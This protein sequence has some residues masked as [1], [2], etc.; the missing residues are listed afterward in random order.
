MEVALSEMLPSG[1]VA[2]AAADWLSKVSGSPVHPTLMRA[3]ASSE[4]A[5]V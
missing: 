3:A 2:T 5:A 4:T 1:L